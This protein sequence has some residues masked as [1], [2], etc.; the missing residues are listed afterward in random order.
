MEARAVLETVLLLLAGA[1]SLAVRPWRLLAPYG[2]QL[3]PLVTPFLACL[4]VLP[5]LWSWPGLAALPLPL[6]WSGAPLVVLLVG[7]PLAV[8]VITVAGLSMLPIVS[9]PI[10]SNRV[11]PIG[12]DSSPAFCQP[13]SEL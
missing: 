5:W 12:P 7:W 6:H 8:P 2:G 3:P 1:A 13:N 9:P 11:V 10:E 4:T